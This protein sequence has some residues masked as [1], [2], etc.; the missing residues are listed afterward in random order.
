MKKEL[1]LW[2]FI[3]KR[4]GR[5][6]KVML[7]VVA[8]SSGSSPGRQG[9]KMAVG[10]DGQLCGSI[11]GGIMEVKLAELAKARLKKEEPEAIVKRQIHRASAP[12]DRSG[13]ICSGEQTVLFF[14][15]GSEHLKAVR[16]LVRCL[17]N[18]RPAVL[19]LAHN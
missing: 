14:S 19:Q 4:L 17:K 1:N 6:E 8:E 12:L 10:A 13:M 2:Q 3:A 5:K 16:M 15:L 7:L 9:F 11:G 18:Y